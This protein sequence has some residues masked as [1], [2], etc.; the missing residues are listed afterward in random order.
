VPLAPGDAADTTVRLLGEEMAKALNGSVVVTNRPG[1][2]GALGAQT[3]VQAK[4]GGQTL[5]FAQNSALTVLPLIEPQ[6]VTYDAQRDHVPLGI[7]SRTPSVLAMR[8]DAPYRTFAELVEYAKKEPGR[9]RIGHPGGGVGGPLLHSDDRRAHRR[10]IARGPLRWRG[11]GHQM[12]V[13][14]ARATGTTS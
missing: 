7:S 10:A 12:R 11:T 5:L 3:V 1:A 6:S 14:A 4:N 2:G 13:A 9:V 8:S